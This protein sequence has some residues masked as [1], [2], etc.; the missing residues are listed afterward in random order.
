MTE[1]QRPASGNRAPRPLR[2][3]LSNVGGATEVRGD[4]VAAK[5]LAAAFGGALSQDDARLHVHGF[6]SYPARL[7]PQIARKLLDLFAPARGT[8]LDPFCGSGTVLVEARL[9]G[10]ASIGSDINP[11]AI[12]LAKLKVRGA[13]HGELERLV[14]AAQAAERHAHDRRM[15]RA[16]ATHRYPDADTRLFDPHVLLELDGLQDGIRGALEGFVRDGLKLVLSAILTKVSRRAGDTGQLDE[17][18]RRLAAGFTT[19]LFMRKTTELAE[20]IADFVRRLPAGRQE[21]RVS[22]DDARALR[23]VKSASVDLVVTSP[24]YPGNYDYV[25]HHEA[26]LRWLGLDAKAFDDREIGARRHLEPAGHEAAT[27]SFERDMAASLRAIRSA[28]RPGGRAVIVMADAVVGKRP[29]LA[30]PLIR[31]AAAKEGLAWVATASQRRPH[32][33]QGSAG[34]FAGRER[35]EHAILLQRGTEHADAGR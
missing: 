18:P 27:A 32:F 11:L 20:R 14:L 8:V 9:A 30:E 29:V 4:P 2:L 10:R 25:L 3:A 23:E 31:R 26:R 5:Q 17:Q 34:A 7:H 19:R 21:A 15:A 1:P 16:G 13:N 24:P 22:L 12:M 35:A 28:L 33:H 6:H